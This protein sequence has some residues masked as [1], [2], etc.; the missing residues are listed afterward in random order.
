AAGLVSI[1]VAAATAACLLLAAAAIT[2]MLPLPALAVV[3]LYFV[4]TLLYSGWIKRVVLADVFTL[5]GLYSLRVL[6]G[7]AASDIVVSAWTLAFLTFLFLSLALLTRYTEMAKLPDA[8]NAAS[9]LRGRGYLR[10]DIGFVSQCGITSGLVSVLV[11]ALY[12]N[13]PEVHAI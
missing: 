13:S 1:P 9:G 7:G 6:G 8:Q 2:W 12:I 10:T 3:A 5:A 4:T 11:F